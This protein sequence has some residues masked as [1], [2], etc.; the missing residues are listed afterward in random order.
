LIAGSPAVFIAALIV[1]SLS[2]SIVA[3]LVVVVVTY[4]AVSLL[5]AAQRERDVAIT[6]TAG[7]AQPAVS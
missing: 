2:T 6:A 3:W 7:E 1:K 4:A 5:R